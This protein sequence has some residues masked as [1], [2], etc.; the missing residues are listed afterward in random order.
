MVVDQKT[1]PSKIALERSSIRTMKKDLLKLREADTAREN[2]KIINAP[3]PRTEKP[4]EA[5][6][7]PAPAST[8]TQTRE[9][10]DALASQ[11]EK[12]PAPQAAAQRSGAPSQEQR[13]KAEKAKEYANEEEKQQIFLLEKQRLKLQR[14]I[15][16]IAKVKE[17]PILL[18][19]NSILREQKDLRAKLAPIIQEEQKIE[20][21]QK[22]MEA[23]ENET[24]VP[25]EK[26]LLQKERWKLEDRRRAVETSRWS[27]EQ[28]LA[29]LEE[30]IKNMIARYNTLQANESGLTVKIAQTDAALN[31][32]YQ[33]I[34]QRQHVPQ[35]KPPQV[36]AQANAAQETAVRGAEEAPQAR[37]HRES[38]KDIPQPIKEK[39]AQEAKAEE[40]QRRKF[41]EDVDRWA[42]THN[43]EEKGER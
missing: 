15:E 31:A 43:D 39:L 16:E 42:N 19:Q 9:K 2:E 21:A 27:L 37:Q 4:L 1:L 41:M 26:E 25:R 5:V 24:N 23:R 36:H 17:P 10:L 6:K 18:E 28:E 38:L 34:A 30:R 22:V 35:Q 29:K 11:I 7:A 8:P 33:A 12:I 32:I 3:A 13:L 20:S 40:I 14:Q